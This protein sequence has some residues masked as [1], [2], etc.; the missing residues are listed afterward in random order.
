MIA[1]G[2]TVLV[3][4]ADADIADLLATYCGRLGWRVLTAD[5]AADAL[6]LATTEH[7][8]GMV[9]DLPLRGSWG[10]DLIDSVRRDP[11]LADCRTAVTSSVDV[12]DFPAGIDAVLPQPFGRHQVSRLLAVL[13]GPAVAAAN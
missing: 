9:T 1:D 3:V 4:S 2:R 6:S 12:Q 8:D 10:M 13:A 11:G 5:T 7:P